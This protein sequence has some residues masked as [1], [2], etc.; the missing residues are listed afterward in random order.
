MHNIR[1]LPIILV[2]L[3]F[4]GCVEQQNN[5]T[6]FFCPQEDCENRVIVAINNAEYSIDA[7]IYSFTSKNIASALIEAQKRGVSPGA[8]RIVIDSLQSK[9]KY[10][11]DEFLN[12]NNI[13]TRIMPSTMHHKFVVIDD[14]LVITGSYNWTE[15]ANSKNNENLVFIQSKDTAELFSREFFELWI[16]SN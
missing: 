13:E 5:S 3:F 2:F 16:N 8:I 14:S 9:S 1:L 15:N 11:M 12:E 7:A 4:G 6:A 10:S